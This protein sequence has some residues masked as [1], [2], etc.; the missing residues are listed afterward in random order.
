MDHDSKYL[1]PI[2]RSTIGS[3]SSSL[4]QSTIPPSSRS[5]TRL[6]DLGNEERQCED[7]ERIGEDLFQ[8]YLRPF[9]R[10]SRQMC[11]TRVDDLIT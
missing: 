10:K 5:H 4:A 8:V 7:G 9:V 11:T 3:T 1:S 2:N 6:I